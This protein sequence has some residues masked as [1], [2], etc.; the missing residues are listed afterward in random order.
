MILGKCVPLDH[1]L[2]ASNFISFSFIYLSRSHFICCVEIMDLMNA[3]DHIMRTVAASNTK[4]KEG[5]AD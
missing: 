4:M 2:Y 3:G 5:M 1:C